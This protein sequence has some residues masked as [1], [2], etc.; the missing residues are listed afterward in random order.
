MHEFHRDGELIHIHIHIH[1]DGELILDNLVVA[2]AVEF[3]F[4]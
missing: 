2:L 3:S 1:R 4:S